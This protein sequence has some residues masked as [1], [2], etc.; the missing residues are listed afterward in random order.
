MPDLTADQVTALRRADLLEQALDW[1]NRRW[2]KK[3][4]K[5]WRGFSRTEHFKLVQ[6]LENSR[7]LP[8]REPR[9]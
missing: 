3:N 9:K 6:R 5:R 1:Q 7:R 8:E 4:G 2:L